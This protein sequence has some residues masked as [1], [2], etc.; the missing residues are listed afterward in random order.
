[1]QTGTQK[2]LDL[3]NEYILAHTMTILVVSGASKFWVAM[4]FRE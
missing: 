2:F 1:M 3:R 4:I